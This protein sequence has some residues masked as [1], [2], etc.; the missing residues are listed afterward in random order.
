MNSCLVF[1]LQTQS[2]HNIP[3]KTKTITK[4]SPSLM[5]LVVHHRAHIFGES[6]HYPVSH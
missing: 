4:L 5:R 2:L 3:Y 6:S 1:S